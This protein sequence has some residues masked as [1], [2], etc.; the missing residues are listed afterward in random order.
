VPGEL[1][2]YL[3]FEGRVRGRGDRA[4]RADAQRW[5]ALRPGDPWQVEPLS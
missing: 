5:L 2:S 1:L 4:R 3:F